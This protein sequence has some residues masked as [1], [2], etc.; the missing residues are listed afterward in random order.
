LHSHVARRAA[1]QGYEV[2]FQEFAGGHDYLAWGGTLADG[3]IAL[4]GDA[5]AKTLRE[6]RRR[7]NSASRNHREMKPK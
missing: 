7:N 2:R 6:H 1:R 3:L 5:A 4:M